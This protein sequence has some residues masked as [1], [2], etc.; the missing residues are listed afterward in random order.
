MPQSLGVLKD[1]ISGAT[2]AVDTV[3]V[4]HTKEASAA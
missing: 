4:Q 3:M 1:D 2:A